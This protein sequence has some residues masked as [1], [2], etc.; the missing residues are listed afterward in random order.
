[1][2]KRKAK[3]PKKWVYS[4]GEGRKEM[5]ALLGGKGANLSEMTSLGI[6]VPPGFTIT[7]EACI[8]YTVNK[9][10]PQGLLDEIDAYLRKLEVATGKRLGDPEKP[11]LL[12]VRS[13]AKISMPGMMDTVLNIGLNESTLSGLIARTGD[14]RFARD[15]YR[16]LI[17]MF[18]N[19]V[20]G[21]KHSQFETILNR[22][23]LDTGAKLD[24]D[25]TTEALKKIAEQ[26][27]AL[28]TQET[29]KGFPH[30]PREQLQLA[31]DAVFQSWN[32]PRANSY[33]EI[34]GIAHDLGTAVN[35]QAMVFGNLGK[36]SGTGVLFTRDPATGERMLYAEYLM[37][38]QGEDVVAG[39]RTPLPIKGLAKQMPTIYKEL[40]SIARSVE[41]HYKDMQDMEFTIEEG[42]LYILQTRTG[43]RS[44]PAAI[45]IAVE[46]EREG[47]ITKE[48]AVLR[49]AP[50]QLEGVM[51]KRIDP[52]AKAKVIA[53]GLPASPG[54]AIGKVVFEAH[55]AHELAGRGEKAIL[56]RPETSP[57]DIEG[58]YASQGILTSRGGM[59][60]HAAIVAR[61]MGK[62]CVVGCEQ[63]HISEKEKQFRVGSMIVREGDVLTLNGTTGEV[64]LGAVRLIEPEMTGEFRTLMGWADSFRRL[65][66]LAN[67]DT[68]ADAAKAVGFGAEGIGLCRTEHMFFEVDR[69]RAVR[70]MIMA[71]NEEGRRAALEKILPMQKED[72]IG[73]FKA[74]KGRPVT[75][76]LLDPPLHE[77]LP[78]DEGEIASIAKSLK[79]SVDAVKERLTRLHEFNPMLGHRGCRLAITFPEICEMQTRAI[80]EAAGELIRQG[81]PVKPEIMIP[82]V[83]HV[84]EFTH[85]KK[86]VE[87][88][89]AEVCKETGLKLTYN[90][91][92]MIEVPRAC[93]TAD[94]IAKHAEFFSFGTNDLTQ[95][96][97]GFSRDDINKFLPEYLA[98]GILASDPFQHLDQA[99]VGKLIQQGITLGRKARKSLKLGICGEHGGDPE[100][101]WFCHR[102]GLDY[103]S[104]SPYRVPVARLAA[105]QAALTEK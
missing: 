73:I 64:L 66:V 90:T 11:L 19:V 100:S 31:I 71:H 26:Y 55:L 25:L 74:M 85:L 82:L 10:Y 39:I 70:E 93:T 61:G 42:K 36:D 57:E 58:M 67:A 101:I 8:H 62:C 92:T 3:Q 14:E 83:G 54:A 7:T 40:H 56:V 75:I 51:H 18:G 81:K 95:M 44:S 60:S 79:T 45:R 21:V 69:I 35:V 23:K 38:A 4:F 84:N 50:E 43:K 49:I 65:G 68:P 34:H 27:L 30:E 86:V 87:K 103:V 41:R 1:M 53:K 76:R 98:R 29:D 46:M 5:S 59:T 16:R 104:C 15:C 96:T 28:I 102:S 6:P 20:L 32:N 12:S 52:K 80:L 77:F 94:E 72:F 63:I 89:A 22:V 47:L 91:G 37:N 17:Q 2:A 33:R 48:T 105:A 9:V 78:D 24:T 13:G 97:F 88:V 99:G